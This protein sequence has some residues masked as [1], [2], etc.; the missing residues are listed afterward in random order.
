MTYNEKKKLNTYR[1]MKAHPERLR[2][3]RKMGK[4]PLSK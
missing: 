1:W 3:I 4:Y 2:E